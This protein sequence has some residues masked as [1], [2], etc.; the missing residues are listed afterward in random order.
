MKQ[1]KINEVSPTEEL[2]QLKKELINQITE[3]H[4]LRGCIKKILYYFKVY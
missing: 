2:K 4:K 1:D 3:I